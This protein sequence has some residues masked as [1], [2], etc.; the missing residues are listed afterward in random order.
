MHGAGGRAVVES[1]ERS[2]ADEGS[3]AAA[4]DIVG[5]GG[6]FHDWRDYSNPLYLRND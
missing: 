5:D 3:G 2:G 4:V 1:G 6:V